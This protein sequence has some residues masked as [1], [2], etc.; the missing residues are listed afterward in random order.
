MPLFKSPLTILAID[1]NSSLD[2]ISQ[3]RIEVKKERKKE[4][5]KKEI[6]IYISSIKGC[7]LHSRWWSNKLELAPL[8][9][10]RLGPTSFPPIALSPSPFTSSFSLL[11]PPPLPPRPP[12]NS[13]HARHFAKWV[14]IHA[15]S[16]SPSPSSS[17]FLPSSRSSRL[18]LSVS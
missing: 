1:L 4:E 7:Y 9:T 6:Y 5:R 2:R 12:Q 14:L 17:I 15:P 18:T 16:S 3:I 11:V 8:P 13:L 10:V